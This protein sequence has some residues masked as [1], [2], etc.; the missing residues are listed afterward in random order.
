MAS[1]AEPLPR[2]F[3]SMTPIT[4]IHEVFQVFLQPIRAAYGKPPALT[5]TYLWDNIRENIARK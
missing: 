1:N 3:C 2:M 4:N 5:F